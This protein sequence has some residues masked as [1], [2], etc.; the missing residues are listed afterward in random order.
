MERRGLLFVVSAPSGAGKT[1]LCKELVSVVPGLQQ[2]ISYTTRQPRPGEVHGREYFF[3]DEAVF[4]GMVQRNEFAEWAP[5]YGHFYG[6]PRSA[7]TD[8]MEKGIDVLLEIDVQGAMQIKKKFAD[9]IYIYIL[10]PS[11]KALRARLLQRGSDSP[12]EVQRRLQKAREEVW[13]YREYYYIVRNED[14]KQALKELEAIV[15]A[16][17]SKTK[18]LDIAWLEE[19]FIRERD[20]KS[21]DRSR[22]VTTQRRS[23]HDD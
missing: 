16:E 19:N 23:G 20:D 3:V 11:I 8:M 5:V 2:S 4:Q 10:P 14:M 15:L 6:T 21:A 1:T 13:S 18:R 17:R 22:S 12:E 9:A 7:L